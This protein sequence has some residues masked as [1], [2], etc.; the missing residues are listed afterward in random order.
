MMKSDSITLPF[1]ILLAGADADD[2]SAFQQAYHARG[3]PVVITRC[4][5]GEVMKQI[6]MLRQDAGAFYDLLITDCVLGDQG[7]EALA[8][9]P[10][11]LTS[12]PPLPA[13]LLIG[14]ESKSLI[15]ESSAAGFDYF[16]Y[17][18]IKDKEGLYLKLLPAILLRTV[19]QKEEQNA[20]RLAEYALRESE[21]K[22]RSMMEAMRDPVY[23]CSPD[24]R[25]T[26]MN[27]AMIRRTGYN[28]VG[29]RCYRALHD[30]ES[31]CPWCLHWKTQKGEYSESEV[32]SPKDSRFYL[33]SNS[34]IFHSDG[35]ISK[36]TIFRDITEIRRI[37]EE[38]RRSKEIAES[39][40]RAKDEFMSNMSHEIRTP[41]NAVIGMLDL[42]LF[43]DPG[44]QQREFLESAR[45]AADS[46]MMLID[47]LLSFSAVKSGQ[48]RP[49]EKSVGIHS[50][51]ENFMIPLRARTRSKSLGL[52]LGIASDVP[53]VIVTDPNFLRQI[54]ANLTDNAVKF[55]EKGGIGIRVRGE[56][57]PNLEPRTSNLLFEI[58]DTGIG[59][60]SDRIKGI[61][62]GFTQADGY[63]TRIFGGIGIG[64]A[65]SR[66]LVE[67]LG[68]RIW[69]ESQEGKG[70]TFYFTIRVRAGQA[71]S[72]QDFSPRSRI[73]LCEKKLKILLTEDNVLNRRLAQKI[74]ETRGHE[75]KS[76]L[77][78]KEA[79]EAFEREKFD[80]IL[81]DVSMPVMDGLEATRQIREKERKT[82]GHIPIIAMTAYAMKEDQERCIAAGMDT[83]MAKPIRLE[84]F[85]SVAEAVIAKSSPES[86]I[87]GNDLQN[88][89]AVPEGNDL[90]SRSTVPEGNDLQSRSTMPGDHD[91]VFKMEELLEITG[92][93]R[94]LAKEVIRLYLASLPKFM[95][96]IENGIAQGDSKS[97]EFGSHALKGMSYNLSAQRVA[98]TALELEKM[99]RD[100]NLSGAGEMYSKLEAEVEYLKEALEVRSEK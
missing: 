1:K 65:I 99:G 75:C 40:N 81:M 24:F 74:L 56:L 57:T 39:A 71:E 73:S 78:G 51:M 18:L 17:C 59:I 49:E 84:K 83:Y 30:R 60:P 14:T 22:Y 50:F 43:T 4:P 28:A 13:V 21:E 89:S 15:D 8:S 35:T 77:N 85:L 34:P 68:G 95:A 41:M 86:E 92:G 42:M 54:L 62:D 11:P 33:M 31:A 63:A 2:V 44:H 98:K 100:G 76:A 80:L 7:S 66:Q 37:E 93:N 52:S 69:A 90:Q 23:I 88:R 79:V 20:G 27:P 16:D 6:E 12:D 25:V 67:M 32:C 29:E 64:T 70:S 72:V 19:Q 3:I 61:F 5:P 45:S 38:L 47:G 82:G 53:P 94:E 36:M 46:L 87:A 58:S 91:K 26:F 55:T 97:V 48:I 9:Y 96:Q 10:S